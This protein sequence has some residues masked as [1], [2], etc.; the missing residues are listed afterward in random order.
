V[1]AYV[2]DLE[3]W[4]IETLAQLASKAKD[5]RAGSAIWVQRD[6]REDK[7]AALGVRI[8][9]WVT[10]LWLVALNV[11][12]DLTHFSGYRACGVRGPMA[13]TSLARSGHWRH[14]GRCGRG[15]KTKFRENI[16]IRENFMPRVSAAFF[17]LG[18]C[19]CVFGMLWGMHMGKSRF[20]HDAGT[21]R[22]QSAGLGDDGAVRPLL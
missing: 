9:R 17:A 3:Q 6:M 13:C 14:H 12:P 18:V 1:R 7:I 5:A 20:H 16:R 15:A 10:L 22:S 21:C 11:D 8:K 2:R 4:L 19:L